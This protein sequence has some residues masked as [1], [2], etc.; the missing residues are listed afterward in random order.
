MAAH[1]ARTPTRNKNVKKGANTCSDKYKFEIPVFR[2]VTTGRLFIWANGGDHFQ[3]NSH[4]FAPREHTKDSLNNI[5]CP[6]LNFADEI[7]EKHV[8][9]NILNMILELW[10]GCLLTSD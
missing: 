8:P 1:V 4:S 5:P 7:I 6:S 10:S 9:N 3:H 2:D